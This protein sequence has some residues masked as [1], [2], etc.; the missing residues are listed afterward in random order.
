MLKRLSVMLFAATLLSGCFVWRSAPPPKEVVVTT[1]P[2][3]VTTTPP[4]VA[5]PPTVVACPA[6]TILRSDGRC[7]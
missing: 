4:V 3:V 7:W 5:G 6:G 1:T 2:P